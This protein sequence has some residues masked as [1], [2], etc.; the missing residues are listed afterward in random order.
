M[1]PCGSGA[2]CGECRAFPVYRAL[3]L[4]RTVLAVDHRGHGRGLRAESPF[5][6][7]ECADD[8]AALLDLLGIKRAIMAGYS[9]GGAVAMLMWKRRPDLVGRLVLSG[10][11]L[12]SRSRRRERLLWRSL[13]MMDLVLRVGG[14]DGFVQRYLRERH[15]SL[16]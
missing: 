6:L 8:A 15:G 1:D 14:G 3:A 13:V 5:S 10:T 12:E 9:M 16:A 2:R 11:A 7:E 4:H